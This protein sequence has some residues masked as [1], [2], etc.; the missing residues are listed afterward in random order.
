MRLRVLN[1]AF[2]LIFFFISMDI[3]AD[4]DIFLIFLLDKATKYI[5]ISI[6]FNSL[7]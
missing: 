1:T 6:M 4:K 7:L 2:F 3:S 5:I